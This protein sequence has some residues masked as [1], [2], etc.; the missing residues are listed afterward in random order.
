MRL[1]TLVCLVLVGISSGCATMRNPLAAKADP[2]D[3]TRRRMIA[4]MNA[5]TEKGDLAGA[6]Q[7][8]AQLEASDQSIKQESSVIPLTPGRSST[9]PDDVE[10]LV[11]R[12]VAHDPPEL[13]EANRQKYQKFSPPILKQMLAEYERTA[14]FGQQN[15]NH[16]I[17][18]GN[19]SDLMY[20]QNATRTQNDVQPTVPGTDLISQRSAPDPRPAGSQP[21]G[22]QS[23][24]PT[25]QTQGSSTTGTA[26]TLPDRNLAANTTADRE[27]EKSRQDGGLQTVSGEMPARSGIAGSAPAPATP[28]PF[29]AAG[30][31]ATQ[32][33]SELPVI[34]PG[35]TGLQNPIVPMSATVPA[36]EPSLDSSPANTIP[37]NTIPGNGAYGNGGVSLLNQIA[38]LDEN[39][40]TEPSSFNSSSSPVAVPSNSSVVGGLLPPDNVNPG[41]PSFP[42]STASQ[43]GLPGM[44]GSG[45]QGVQ[46]IIP[47]IKDA[48]GRTLRNFGQTEPTSNTAAVT[49]SAGQADVSTLIRNLEAELMAVAPGQTDADRL[50]YIRK[51]VNLRMLHLVAGDVGQAVEPIPGIASAD[52]EFWQ[53]MIWSVSN[54]FDNQGMPEA[55]VRSAETIEQLRGAIAQLSHTAD[56]KLRNTTFCHRIVSFGNY[57][58]FK[59]DRFTTGQPVLLYAEVENF[60]S[61]RSSNDGYR[62]VLQSVIEIYRADDLQQP[63]ATIPLATDTTEDFCRAQRRDYFHSYE[64][65]IPPNL[66]PGLYT[67]VLRIIDQQSRKVATSR[68]NFEVE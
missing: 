63:A 48:A 55:S 11:D 12:L 64:F 34:S 15:L 24:W 25:P 49:P 13:R 28:N 6:R 59:E 32:Q 54:Y 33:T 43:S 16:S 23:P 45:V 67:L 9:S 58:R 35:N 38:P 20:A 56:L 37:A 61:L 52:Q 39:G 50:E 1:V 5:L 31:Q 66:K 10:K 8:L 21:L 68:V 26:P 65:S 30:Q 51:H 62:T 22:T 60:T 2:H 53:Q 19:S 46:Q 44:L 7:I 4:E 3:A 47:R 27:R 42:D 18:G 17:P 41:A 14:E 36:S 40:A 29:A 57:D